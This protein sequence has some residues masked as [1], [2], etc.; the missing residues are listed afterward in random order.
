[1]EFGIGTELTMREDIRI[2]A[3]RGLLAASIVVFCWAAVSTVRA[4]RE[5]NELVAS[6]KI[7]EAFGLLV[8]ALGAFVVWWVLRPRQ[9]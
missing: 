6:A 1:M 8:V 9:P 2:R 3:R 5:P 4:L 7:G